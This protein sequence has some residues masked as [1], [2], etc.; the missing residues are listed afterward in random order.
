[1]KIRSAVAVAVAGA[2]LLA[3]TALLAPPAARA[4]DRTT[5]PP[6]PPPTTPPTRWKS[7]PTRPEKTG[8]DAP[9]PAAVALQPPSPDSR[10]KE[11]TDRAERVVQLGHDLNEHLAGTA[12]LKEY[13]DLGLLYERLALDLQALVL[14]LQ[15]VRNVSAAPPARAT[16][17]EDLVQHAIRMLKE[18]E[19][20]HGTIEK[21]AAP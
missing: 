13:R 17:A 16:A 1:M 5:Q 4:Q 7:D 9:T 11:A 20:L 21:G 14:Q 12:T 8:A 15:S 3:A 18:A 6:P 2:V 10:M 19:R